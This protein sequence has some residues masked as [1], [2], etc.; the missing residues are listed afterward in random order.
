[1]RKHLAAAELR[2]IGGILMAEELSAGR[3][4]LVDFSVD[5]DAGNCAR[6]MR[7]PEHHDEALDAFFE[8]T[9]AD[10]SRFN[11]VG[12]WHSHPCYPARPSVEDVFT[13]QSLVEEEPSIPF[14]ILLITRMRRRLDMS[15]QLFQRGGFRS[16]VA[17]V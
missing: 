3:F 5:L 17:I 6:F 15:A 1:M 16:E 11:Y 4:K 13:M 10:Y 7:R 14:S 9:G 2:E 12:E 8:R